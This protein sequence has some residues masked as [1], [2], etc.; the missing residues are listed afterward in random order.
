MAFFCGLDIQKYQI[1]IC[2]D[3]ILRK[4][5]IVLLIAGL[6]TMMTITMM[7]MMTITVTSQKVV[8]QTKKNQSWNL[9]M[10]I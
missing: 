7:A 6:M 1:N 5:M 3:N 4:H 9:V 2:T 8:I 10:I